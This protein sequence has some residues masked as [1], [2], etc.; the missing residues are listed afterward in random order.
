MFSIVKVKDKMRKYTAS[1]GI[2]TKYHRIS[3]D[4]KSQW[5]LHIGIVK[6]LQLYI[7]HLYLILKQI[8]ELRAAGLSLPV[9]AQAVSELQESPLWGG[10]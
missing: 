2:Q 10:C 7:I 4:V 3:L 9:P 5:S 6:V 8:P 1:H